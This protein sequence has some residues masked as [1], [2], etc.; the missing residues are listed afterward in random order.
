MSSRLESL[1]EELLENI[2]KYLP[3]E[4]DRFRCCL[5]SRHL[6]RL[7]IP[8]LYSSVIICDDIPTP[9]LLALMADTSKA[10]LVKEITYA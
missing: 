3:L 7:A 10:S 2:L 6:N 8:V 1:P 4:H 9:F 5:V